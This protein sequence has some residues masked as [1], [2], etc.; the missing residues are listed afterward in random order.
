[1]DACVA[2]VRREDCRWIPKPICGT[3]VAKL[4]VPRPRTLKKFGPT[5]LADDLLINRPQAKNISTNKTKD[6]YGG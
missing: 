1:M 4:L 2:S 6:I 5:R 3:L